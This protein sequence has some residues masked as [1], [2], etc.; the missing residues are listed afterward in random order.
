MKDVHVSV[1]LAHY[2]NLIRANERLEVENVKITREL[3]DLRDKAARLEREVQTLDPKLNLKNLVQKARTVAESQ[4]RCTWD[5]ERAC[6]ALRAAIAKQG[7]ENNRI[8]QIKLL[9]EVTGLGLRESKYFVEG[10]N[11]EF[12]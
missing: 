6:D 3:Y 1:P 5:F 4:G 7:G 8:A 9:R 12:S 2:E 11:H 10:D